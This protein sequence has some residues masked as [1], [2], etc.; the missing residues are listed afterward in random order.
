MS[1]FWVKGLNRILESISKEDI[2]DFVF[3]GGSA[4]SYYLNHRLSEDIDLFTSNENLDT[5]KINKILNNMHK[6]GYYIEDV[7]AVFSS[8]HRKSLI[9]GIKVEFVAYDRS[10]LNKEEKILMNNLK[11][12]EL[13]TLIGMKAY[14]LP[15]R[16]IPVIRD[17]YDIYVITKK[18]GIEKVIK[19][20]DYLFSNSFNK[21]I[22]FDCLIRAKDLLKENTI[23]NH[24]APIYNINK[25]EMSNFFKEEIKKYIIKTKESYTEAYILR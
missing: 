11:I 3:V 17:F 15:Q 8:M 1:E 10:F 21:R 2:N 13:N 4:L 19:E 18:Y 25:E 24:L 7:G 9:L 14:T 22:F 12:A 20:A 23:E 5:E 16:K 6:R